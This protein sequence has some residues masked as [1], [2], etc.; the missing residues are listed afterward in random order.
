MT[1]NGRDE[2]PGRTSQTHGEESKQLVAARAIV[3]LLADHLNADLSV[4]L[5][6]GEVLPLGS[7]AKDDIQ[8][9]VASP[10]A[11]RRLLLRPRLETI[12]ELYASAEIEV[13]GAHPLAAADR[14]SHGR[15]VKLARS[16]P[17][18]R[19][20]R[21]AIPFLFASTRQSNAAPAF[22]KRHGE[23]VR[24]DRDMIRFHYDVSNRFYGLFLDREMVYSSAYFSHAAEDLDQA[25][26][27]KLDQICRK[28]RLKPGDKLLDIGCGWGALACHAARVYGADVHGIT[29]S[30]TQHEH[31]VSK[32]Q[33]LG[34]QDKVIIQL[35]DYRS[36]T[37]EGTYDKVSQIEMF[38]HVGFD[39]H[40]RH[41]THIHHLLKPRGLY[42][43]QSSVRRGGRDL[44]RF[45]RPTGTTRT[46][47]RYIFPGGEL[48]YIGLTVTNLGRFG[49]EVHDVQN[50][51]EHFLLT[52][53]HWIERLYAR[54]EEA[55]AE[56]GWP[57]TRLWL[58]YF[59]V[60]AK[61]FERGA[62]LV[63]QTVASKRAPGPSGLPL[64]RES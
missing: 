14:W 41:F 12:F 30:K 15:A 53:K 54:R 26:I 40:E 63:Y 33:R 60:F 56:V 50:M 1:S 52:L 22:A 37:G 62:V 21:L 57:R 6:N 31:A 17:T 8:I 2:T 35:G 32:V 25:Q 18:A 48:D 47:T 44:S 28:L 19:L 39:A 36:L 23:S 64:M 20:L 45:R 61:G 3:R 9:A 58:A 43:H 5:W 34:L 29:L 7:N 27:S 59:S 11:V 42:L 4:R 10:Q 51:R 46:I 38:E 13:I 16:L 24:P 55:A 49:F